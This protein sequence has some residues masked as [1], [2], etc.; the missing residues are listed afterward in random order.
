MPSP[1]PCPPP[2]GGVLLQ[3]ADACG[4][5]LPA[6]AHE[7]LLAEAGRQPTHATV[8]SDSQEALEREMGRNPLEAAAHE[9]SEL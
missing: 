2:A 5:Y 1:G 6:A 8:Q 4:S 9:A 3:L 7:A